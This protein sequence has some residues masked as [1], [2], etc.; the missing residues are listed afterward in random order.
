MK[1]LAKLLTKTVEVAQSNPRL[2][3]SLCDVLS[4]VLNAPDP[5][6]AGKRAA[7]AAAAREAYRISPRR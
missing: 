1:E 6:E 5:V 2:V 3:R 7:L 4:A